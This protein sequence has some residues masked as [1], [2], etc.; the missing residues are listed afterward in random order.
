M[1]WPDGDDSGAELDADGHVVVGHEAA[2]AEA[3]GQ[4]GFTTSRVADADELGY[5]VPGWGGHVIGPG[6]ASE[7]SCTSSLC[8][9][10]PGGRAL[11]L[12]SL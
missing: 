9:A 11:E 8:V 12:W 2:L 4:G 10:L 6:G 3:D 5:V 7:G 1:G